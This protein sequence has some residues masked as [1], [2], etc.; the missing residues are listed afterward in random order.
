MTEKPKIRSLYVLEDYEY[1]RN[2]N[3]VDFRWTRLEITLVSQME[4]SL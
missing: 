1:C 4:G 2:R 3:Q